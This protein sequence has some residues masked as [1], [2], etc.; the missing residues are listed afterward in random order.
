MALLDEFDVKIDPNGV[1]GSVDKPDVSTEANDESP[2]NTAESSHNHAIG[3]GADDE[4]SSEQ[5]SA[6]CEGSSKLQQF[7]TDED[8]EAPEKNKSKEPDGEDDE[9]NISDGES[10]NEADEYFN[11]RRVEDTRKTDQDKTTDEESV[12]D[13]MEELRAR[14]R[15]LEQRI[16]LAPKRMK[17]YTQYT[18]ILEER[19]SLLEE[20]CI[21]FDRK[22]VEEA[23]IFVPPVSP[24]ANS[25][26]ILNL[27][28]DL[29]F[30]FWKDFSTSGHE[31]GDD[32]AQEG[33]Y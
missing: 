12:D 32:P 10:I 11:L 30:K 26:P 18:R 17:Q 8:R 29:G 16:K 31:I 23:G 5:M 22:I 21:A 27:N 6:E 3:P 25:S 1:D 19:I 20:R 15:G 4:C 24:E 33:L 7:N 28:P 13:R 14:H 9:D 2:K